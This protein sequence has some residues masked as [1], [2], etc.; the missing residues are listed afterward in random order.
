MKFVFSGVV[1]LLSCVYFFACKDSSNTVSTI[2]DVVFPAKKISYNR[3]VQPLFNVACNNDACHDSKT[4]AGDLDLSDY[5]GIRYAK[6]GIVIPRDT[7]SSRLLWSV[8][9]RL[10]SFPMPPM[11]SL[12]LNQIQGLKQWIIEGATD[13][14]P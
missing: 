9:G 5:Y 8:E 12:T 14:I 3:H 7:V 1:F 4:K 10:G 13:T 2:D 11:R 6:P